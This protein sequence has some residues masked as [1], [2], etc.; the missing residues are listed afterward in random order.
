M[1]KL[2]TAL[3]FSL[4][5]LNPIWGDENFH[6][7]DEIPP[8][9]SVIVPV[10]T[11]F[12]NIGFN[13][14]NSFT[15]NY[16]MNFLGAFTESWILIKTGLD[17]DWRQL[18]Y[19][20]NNLVRSGF[21]AVYIGY[22]IPVLLPVS[23]YGIGR[24]KMDE[25]LQI[26]GLALAQTTFISSSVVVMLKA[27]TGVRGPGIANILEHHRINNQQNFSGD[28]SWG[29]GRR[30][31]TAGWPSGHTANA[32]AMATVLTELYRGNVIVMAVSWSY[33]AY[34]AFGVSVSVHWASE[35]LAGLFIGLAV[36]QTVGRSFNKLLK[37]E[38]RPGIE[39]SF[40]LTPAFAGVN[41]RL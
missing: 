2:I 9:E 39:V 22:S 4:F 1:P 17:W 7:L 18:A 26:A 24:Y 41:L 28:Y 32:V 34:I 3:L 16:G 23:L 12:H 21:P 6:N 33:A 10:K 27:I 35:V 13:T 11:I 38:A 30:G 15:A 37:H 29:F 19:N 25:K 5:L 40:C 20:N 14:L 36:G 8:K 31:F